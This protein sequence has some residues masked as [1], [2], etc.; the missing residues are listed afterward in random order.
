MFIASITNTFL[1]IWG[2]LIR[3]AD[4]C[5]ANPT[6]KSSVLYE[7]GALATVLGLVAPHTGYVTSDW[8]LSAL[9]HQEPARDSSTAFAR[10]KH[11][12]FDHIKHSS[13]CYYMIVRKIH[14]IYSPG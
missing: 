8:F 11:V 10:I 12:L 2:G 7:V 9:G 3:I 13:I 6:R 5:S 4:T 14:L 1:V